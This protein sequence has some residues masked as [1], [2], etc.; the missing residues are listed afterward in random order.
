MEEWGRPYRSAIAVKVVVSN[1][2]TAYIAVE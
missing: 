1:E 2:M